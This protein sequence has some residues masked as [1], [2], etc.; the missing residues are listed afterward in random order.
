VID[1]EL[2]QANKHGEDK[3]VLFYALLFPARQKLNT[4][5]IFDVRH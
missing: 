3:K 4:S 5:H 2:L 1:V